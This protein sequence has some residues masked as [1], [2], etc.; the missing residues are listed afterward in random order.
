[1]TELE[2]DG[3]LDTLTGVWKSQ[4]PEYK[5]YIKDKILMV[6]SVD[7]EE[8]SKLVYYNSETK[9]LIFDIWYSGFKFNEKN[10][11]LEIY[12]FDFN[13]LSDEYLNNNFI[14]DSPPKEALEEL[15]N[16]G[17][18]KGTLSKN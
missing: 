14:I 6:E 10:Q 2:E 1:M 16:Y 13:K 12:I 11:T 5:F 4:E 7:G 3:L 8:P 18:P 17:Y 15:S 9:I